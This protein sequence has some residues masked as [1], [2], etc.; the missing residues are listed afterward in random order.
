MTT[1][2]NTNTTIT[3]PQDSNKH[4]NGLTLCLIV[5]LD[6]EAH[7][8]VQARHPRYTD[9]RKGRPWVAHTR[10]LLTDDQNDTDKRQDKRAFSETGVDCTGQVLNF[11]SYINCCTIWGYFFL[12]K[13]LGVLFSKF[14]LI[15]N[16]HFLIFSFSF[17]RDEGIKLAFPC[18]FNF[19]LLRLL[20]CGVCVFSRSCV[21]T[22]FVFA[23]SD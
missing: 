13:N 5:I 20:P 18:A 3:L 6:S 4:D 8:W 19:F 12:K 2:T 10:R 14:L 9:A 22:Q 11:E 17:C 16:S 23:L 21:V 7:W 15:L 1:N